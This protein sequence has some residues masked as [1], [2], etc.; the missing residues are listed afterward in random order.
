M[1][2]IYKITSPSGKVYVGQTIRSF[3]ERL[4]QHKSKYS[5]CTLLKR[6]INKYGDEMKY[7]IIEDNIPTEHLDDREK[8][9][10]KELKSLAPGGYNCNT[11]GGAYRITCQ[12]NKDNISNAK[13]KSSLNKKGYIGEIIKCGNVFRPRFCNYYLSY[14]AFYTREEAIEVLK[15]YSKD[16]DNFSKVEGTY[17]KPIGNVHKRGNTW[18]LRYKGKTIGNYQTREE[19]ERERSSLL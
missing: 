10:I 2:L 9:W 6:A 19:A 16:P 14:G 1:G 11:G 18:Q 7:E 13:R 4:R 15:E 3:E 12:E 8:Y 17:K 5:E